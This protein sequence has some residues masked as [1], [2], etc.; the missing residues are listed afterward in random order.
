MGERRE[1]NIIT[2]IAEV[3]GSA[4]CYQLIRQTPTLTEERDQN[5]IFPQIAK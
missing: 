5:S 3:V 2:P 1:Q 4:K